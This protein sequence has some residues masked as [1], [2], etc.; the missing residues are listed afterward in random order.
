MPAAADWPA[1]RY[2]AWLYSPDSQRP[3]IE[4]LFDIEREVATSVRPGLDH[5]VAH[6][7]LQWWR[8]ECQRCAAGRAV[9]PLTRAL[10]TAAQTSP[11]LPRLEG[12]VGLVDMATWDLA[13][14][15]FESRTELDAYCARWSAAIIEPIVSQA[16]GTSGAWLAGG[17]LREL[18]MLAHA[19]EEAHAGRLRV[20]LDELQ[21]AG[22]DPE[23]LAHPPWPE[24]LAS[25]L[26]Q[27][28]VA[29][30]AVLARAVKDIP[31]AAQPALRG[32]L[33]WTRLAVRESTRAQQ[34]LP[35]V[36]PPR[37]LAGLANAWYAWQ[38]ARQATIG[39]LRPE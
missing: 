18:E 36:P 16:L 7:R 19:S 33:V 20:P 27:R 4:A 28:Q 37:R 34:A 1:T 14:A 24:S 10:I 23:S 35:G 2:F 21:L 11:H 32:L 31:P 5:Q 17:A 22:A 15:T 12:L 9:H 30:Q 3:M 25:L 26:E 8:E 39:R 6:A 13:G 38:T 29:L